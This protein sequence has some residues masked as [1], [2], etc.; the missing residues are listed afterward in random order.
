MNTN[1]T[2]KTLCALLD[3]GS[4]DLAILKDTE[5]NIEDIIYK[6]QESGM[7]PTLENIFINIVFK[8]QEELCEALSEYK[9]SKK[10]IP[11]AIN[12]LNPDE[13]LMWYFNYLDSSISLRNKEIYQ[14]FIPAELENIEKHT[15]FDF[16]EA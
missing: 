3:C 12:S 4:L 1:T 8:A 16:I 7:Q 11:K 10:H 15:G 6:L 2:E 5:Y 13:D 9:N 14:K